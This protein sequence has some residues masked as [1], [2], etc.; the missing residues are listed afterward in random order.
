MTEACPDFRYARSK[1]AGTSYPNVNSGRKTAPPALST[2][3]Q[4]DDLM[5]DRTQ[6][7]TAIRTI[8]MIPSTIPEALPV[9]PWIDPRPR[10]Q[11]P[12]Q[13]SA[14]HHGKQISAMPDMRH[15]VARPY[16]ISSSEICRASARVTIHSLLVTGGTETSSAGRRTRTSASVA[17]EET[18]DPHPTHRSGD[19]PQ[20][21]STTESALNWQRSTHEPHATQRSAS[22]FAWKLEYDSFAGF[23]DSA[24]ARKIP[25]Q[26]V[27]QL[28]M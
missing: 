7:F 3:N 18:Q 14:R 21:S 22:T 9:L 28:Q 13:C 8:P 19:T 24:T 6:Q 23:S 16:V 1:T 20:S 26:H 5:R 4:L 2:A 10:T 11:D 15:Q 17:H 12:F 25:Q 27:Q